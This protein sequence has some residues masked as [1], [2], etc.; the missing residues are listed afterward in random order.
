MNKK[1]KINKDIGVPFYEQIMKEIDK[2]I[3]NNKY[4][5]CELIPKE[6]DLCKIYNVSRPTI[7]KALDILVKEGKLTRIKGKGTYVSSNKISQEFTKSILNFNEEMK[8]KGVFPKT[9]VLKFEIILPNEE[10]KEILNLNL[11]EKIIHFKRLRFVNDEPILV[12]DTFLPCFT[13]EFIEKT[14][15][16]KNS[17]YDILNKNNKQVKKVKRTL[18]IKKSDKD[19]A[20]FL[21]IEINEP[22]FYFETIA[23][24]EN[25]EIVEY[26]KCFY[27]SDKNKFEFELT[28]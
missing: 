28:K 27:R 14:D 19:L 2:D 26:S 22:L 17:F 13:N 11:D 1:E 6:L 16:E 9:K 4:K 8:Q 25:D 24:T 23:Y 7:R 5:Y 3:K 20:E 12:V 10:T 15:L 21:N 18:E